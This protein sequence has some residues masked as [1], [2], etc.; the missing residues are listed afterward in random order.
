MRWLALALAGTLAWSALAAEE[1]RIAPF[2][3][4]K[5]GVEWPP[6]W[7]PLG[8]PKAKMPEFRLVEDA[9]VTVL[10]AKSESAAGT[11]S[12]SLGAGSL[13]HPTLKWR[14]KVDRVVS[15]GD[16][17]TRAHEDFAARVYVFFDVPREALPFSVRAKMKV[18]QLLYDAELPTATICYVWDNKHPVGTHA[19]SP[20]IQTV[21]T[22]VV[23]SGNG[24]ANQWTSEARNLEVDFRAAFGD[25]WK[26]PVPRVKGIAIGLDTDQTKESVTAAFGDFELGTAP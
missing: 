24:Q 14:W 8:L 9:G 26:G 25:F 15:A 17:M 7:K 21:H 18:A 16:M 13:T 22:W 3:S 1:A 20:F 23:Q 4:A 6:G 2:S 10:Q 5:P 12:Y 11:M 19:A